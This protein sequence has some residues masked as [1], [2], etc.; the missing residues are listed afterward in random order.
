MFGFGLA[1]K[2][3]AERHVCLGLQVAGLW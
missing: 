3:V 1:E 2:S